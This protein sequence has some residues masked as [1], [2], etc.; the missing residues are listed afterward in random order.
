ML[1]F[2]QLFLYGSDVFPFLCYYYFIYLFSGEKVLVCSSGAHTFLIVTSG[3]LVST[4]FHCFLLPRVFFFFLCG[5][6]MC[7]F[8]FRTAYYPS[9]GPF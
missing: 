1:L 3:A 4:G 6:G 5:F 8:F 9:N 2:W 7:G